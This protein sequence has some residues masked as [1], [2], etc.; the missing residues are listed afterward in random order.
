MDDTMD[1][2]NW[3]SHP[4]GINRED[5]LQNYDSAFMSQHY[6]YTKMP[7]RNVPPNVQRMSEDGSE[8][9]LAV[10]NLRKEEDTALIRLDFALDQSEAILYQLRKVWHKKTRIGICQINCIPNYKVMP[11]IIV[12]KVT[13]SYK[14]NFQYFYCLLFIRVLQSQ[15]L[16]AIQWL[17]IINLN[18]WHQ[19]RM[20]GIQPFINSL[21]FCFL[22][23]LN[24]ET[25]VCN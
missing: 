5:F 18:D 10:K 3:V 17:K 19:T 22:T 13:K 4:L 6:I 11:V 20:I 2:R 25:S 8:W 14:P 16:S 7:Q 12:G 1:E 15:D 9:H 24:L 21:I 23:N